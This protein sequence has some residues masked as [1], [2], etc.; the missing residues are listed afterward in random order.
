MNSFLISYLFTTSPGINLNSFNSSTKLSIVYE[1]KF[2][3]KVFILLKIFPLSCNFK[4]SL[5]CYVSFSFTLFTSLSLL[6]Y[7][8]A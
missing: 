3:E 5:N 4:S 6:S 8:P 2:S 1:L 7:T